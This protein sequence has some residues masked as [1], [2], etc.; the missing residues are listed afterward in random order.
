MSAPAIR[1]DRTKGSLADSLAAVA[2]ATESWLELRRGVPTETAEA[3][4]SCADLLDQPERLDA[5]RATLAEWM[6]Q[7]YGEAPE[8]ATAGYLMG[9]YLNGP[10][11]LAGL[12]F[13]RLRRVPMLRPRDLALRIA[14]EGRPH[15]DGLALLSDSFACLP[16]DPGRDLPEATVVADEAA[17]ASLLRAR[18]AEH[19]ARF[20]AAFGPTSRFGRRT[21]WAA[22]TDALDSGA[23]LAGRLCGDEV[24][25]VADAALLLP[26]R[27]APF[28]SGSTLR[29]G[30][31]DP[32]AGDLPQW[33]RRRESCCFHF[34]LPG[35]TACDTCPRVMPADR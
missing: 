26:A 7:E 25:G 21:L 27:I 18:F 14:A 35:A 29:F 6:C 12:L 23:W 5:W 11:L 17:L 19:A 1:P 31:D 2:G 32:S 8:R 20:V 24:S 34:A 22:A 28:T 13:H 33:T 3:W 16:D 4:V 30:C 15:P 9:W 10:G